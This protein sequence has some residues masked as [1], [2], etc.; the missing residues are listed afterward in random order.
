GLVDAG[1]VVEL[2]L[3]LGEEPGRRLKAV[4]GPE[5]LNRYPC[6]KHEYQNPHTGQG[7]TEDASVTPPPPPNTATL[8]GTAPRSEVDSFGWFIGVTA[9]SV[10]RRIA[11]SALTLIRRWRDMVHA[12][13]PP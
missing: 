3:D 6:E 8:L 2:S 9:A 4:V 10:G 1:W 12:R 7:Q 13:L 11:R 5:A